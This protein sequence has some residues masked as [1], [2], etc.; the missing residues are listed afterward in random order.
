MF[1]VSANGIGLTYQWQKNDIDI[2][3]AN[4]SVYKI[5]SCDISDN[6]ATFRCVINNSAGQVT[7]TSAILTV[8]NTFS[9]VDGNLYH[10]VKVGSQV[11]MVENLRTTKYNDE[12]LIPIVT[13]STWGALTSAACCVYG[14]QMSNKATHG[15]LYNW[16][17]VETGKLA[18]A[19]WHVAASIEWG[20]LIGEIGGSNIAGGKL[21]ATGTSE[22]TPPNTGATDQFGFHALP[23]G[24]RNGSDF[25][26]LHDNGYW[27]SATKLEGSNT[28]AWAYV[29]LYDKELISFGNMPM[30]SGF[31]VRCVRD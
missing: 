26:T 19:G 16:Y 18:P 23:G 5:A 29:M 28:D 6:N 25:Y 12:T 11:W 22:W 13:D 1:S 31:S 2:S 20:A 14:N 21:K 15:M 4:S 27:W 10:A 24:V 8:N 7:S 17:A 9:D 30:I 3:G